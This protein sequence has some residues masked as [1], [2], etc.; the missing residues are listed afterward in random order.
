ML[1]C[2]KMLINNI[3][4]LDVTIKTE[5]LVLMPVSLDYKEII[6]KEFDKDITLYMH[7]A[8]NENISGVENFVHSSRWGMAEGKELVCAVLKKD[9]QEFVG[10]VGLHRVDTSAPELGGWI[11]KSAHG[12]KYGREAFQ[13]LKKWAEDN[14]DYE[15]LHYPVA[16]ANVASRKIPESMGGVVVKEYEKTNMAGVAWPFVDYRIDKL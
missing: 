5:R 2:I 12:H 3:K 8:P 13:A 11:K 15:Y 6:F 4:L 14:V 7:P 10:I 9:T 1:G 16:A